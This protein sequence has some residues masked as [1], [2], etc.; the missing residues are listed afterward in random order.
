M[1]LEHTSDEELVRRALQGDGQS[2]TALFERHAARL[3]RLGRRHV[4]GALRRRKGESDLVQDALLAAFQNLERFEPAGPGSFA[5]WLDAILEHKAQDGVRRE[6]RA[7]RTVA[8][9][10][11]RV[12]GVQP[13]DP[14]P[15]P[16]SLAG[17]DERAARLRSAVARLEGAQRTVVVLVHQR[18]LTFVEAGRLMGRSADAARMV[19]ARAVTRLADAMRQ[20]GAH[21]RTEARGRAPN[22]AR[23]PRGLA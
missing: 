17:C 18:G 13:V 7:R 16:S 22:H 12:S 23:D 4:V 5:R 19:Y 21:D 20:E 14:G 9:E 2:T 8:R 15:T 10:A 11:G 1:S 3:A 6:L